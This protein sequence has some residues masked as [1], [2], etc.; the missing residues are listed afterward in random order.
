MLWRIKEYLSDTAS[1]EMRLVRAAQ[2]GSH[3][4]FDA[5]IR[6]HEGALRG[7]LLSR[8]GR[9]P[10]EDVLQETRLSCYLALR[11][12]TGKSRFKAWLFGIAYHKCSDHHR[13][14]RSAATET[15]LDD[16]VHEQPDPTDAYA[17]VEMRMFVT[18]LLAELPVVQREVMELYYYGG[19][20]LSEISTL[21]GRNLNTVKAQFYRAHSRAV[22]R[23]QLVTADTTTAEAARLSPR[24]V[25]P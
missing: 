11:S 20:T 12:Y 7:F 15:S 21:L 10:L 16:A 19:L 14:S 24:G 4:A 17:A 13:G 5:L 3:S 23:L 18:S 25:L 2:N 6:Q 9:E 8:V 1:Q 22:E